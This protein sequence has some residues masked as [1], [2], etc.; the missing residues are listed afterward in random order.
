M[1]KIGSV[2]LLT[3]LIIN[4]NIAFGNNDLKHIPWKLDGANER[5]EKYRKGNITL[6]FRL[7]SGDLL[8]S[9]ATINIELKKHKF[10][11]GASVSQ[12]WAYNRNNPNNKI[13]HERFLDIFNYV[14]MTIFWVQVH[15]NPEGPVKIPTYIR[16]QVKWAQDNNLT[17]KGMPLVWYNAIP[18]WVKTESDM[19]KIEARIKYHVQ[20]LIKEFPEITEWGVFNEAAAAFKRHVEKSGIIKW[21]KHKGGINPAVEYLFNLAN[22]AEP[23]NL[24]INNHYTY[25]HKAF[26]DLNQH[27]I[28]TKAGLGAIGIQT[29]MH[30]KSEILAETE[31]WNFIENYS[32]YGKIHLTEVTVPSSIP[33]KDYRAILKYEKKIREA[34]AWGNPEKAPFRPSSPSGEKYQAEYLK[35]FYTLAFSHPAVDT[36]ILWNLSDLMAWRGAAGG[37]LD[38]NHKPEPAFYAL[39]KLIKK[40]WHTEISDELRTDGSFTFIG[41]FGEYTGSIIIDKAKYQF[42]FKHTSPDS[43][44]IIDLQ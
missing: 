34:K 35:D 4:C 15:R 41:F 17:I 29:H 30:M 21:V 16:D 11:F 24:Y 36:I 39:K 14:T 2:F 6:K 32:A 5:I 33:F 10:R 38:R 27:L 9:T 31:M 19:D 40:E 44:V 18:K 26:K 12:T 43:S 25:T 37:I 3:I 20:Y 23:N 8:S 28:S 22:K 7:P 1:K 42:N 13:F